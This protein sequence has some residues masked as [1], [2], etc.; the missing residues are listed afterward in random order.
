[1]SLSFPA[2]LSL[3][4]CQS[5][6]LHYIDFIKGF[7]IISV[8]FLHTLTLGQL[9]D[10]LAVLHIWQAIPLF[11]FVSFFLLF[12]K[13]ERVGFNRYFERDSWIKLLKRVVFP[14]AAAQLLIVS[15][16]LLHGNYRLCWNIMTLGGSGP[17]SYYPYLY[18]Q[19]WMLTPLLYC[20]LQ[21]NKWGG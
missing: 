15:V 12:S 18:I 5:S 6:N 8:L 3:S 7:A 17:G 16:W 4:K 19:L 2:R 21:K 20:F 11:I 10:S 9:N 13:I 1:M 14:F